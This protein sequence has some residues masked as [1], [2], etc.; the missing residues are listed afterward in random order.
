[1]PAILSNAPIATVVD[2]IVVYLQ[3]T[4]SDPKKVPKEYLWDDNPSRSSISISSSFPEN[5]DTPERVPSI[6]V[7]RSA[8]SFPRIAVN[9]EKSVSANTFETEEKVVTCDGGLNVTITCGSASEA[10]SMANFLAIMFISDAPAIKTVVSFIRRFRPVGVSAEMPVKRSAE[11]ERWQVVLS[12][13]VGIQI[14]WFRDYEEAPEKWKRM[15]LVAVSKV[16]AFESAYGSV[17]AGSS[18]LKDFEAKFGFE[19]DSNPKLIESEL[20]GGWYHVIFEG[21]PQ[22]YK[23]VSLKSENEIQLQ[24]VDSDNNP[25]PFNPLVNGINKKYKIVWNDIHLAVNIPTV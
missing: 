13:E 24:A 15:E 25:V 6:T 14:G 16:H 19:N 8:L 10:S 5:D 22:R 17:F 4:F 2:S 9:D 23:V 1:M 7:D 3:Q 20:N 11:V 21:S 18:S 12:I